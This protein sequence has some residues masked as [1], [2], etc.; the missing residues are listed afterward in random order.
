MD[1]F[2]LYLIYRL[3]FISEQILNKTCIFLHGKNDFIEKFNFNGHKSEN[4]FVGN[5]C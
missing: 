1:F 5:K 3:F 4:N 2:L